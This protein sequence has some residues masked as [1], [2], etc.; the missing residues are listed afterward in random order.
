MQMEFRFRK[1]IDDRGLSSGLRHEFNFIAISLIRQLR[2]SGV[3]PGGHPVRSQICSRIRELPDENRPRLRVKV[4]VVI[5]GIARKARVSATIR[6]QNIFE[7]RV[8][9]QSHLERVIGGIVNQ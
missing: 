2:P 7:P 4:V 6:Q 9:A 1:G 3:N 5:I 8:R